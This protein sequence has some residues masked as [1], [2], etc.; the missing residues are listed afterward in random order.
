MLM[1]VDGSGKRKWLLATSELLVARWGWSLA[2]APALE[3][4]PAPGAAR[5]WLRAM[6]NTRPLHHQ[7]CIPKYSV[8]MLKTSY[9]SGKI[10]NAGKFYILGITLV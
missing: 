5:H 1:F 9:D 4:E 2:R 10:E 6:T 8:L 7:V 3:L